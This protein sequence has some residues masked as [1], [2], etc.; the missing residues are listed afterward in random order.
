[1]G[2]TVQSVERAFSILEQF[3]E[4]R[5]SRTAA[6][7]AIEVGLARPTAYRLLQTLQQLGYVRNLN[8]KFEVT[9][10]I[11]RLSAGYLGGHSLAARA[12]PII[13]HLSEQVGEH[14]GI[15]VLDGDDVVTISAADP[16]QSR[17]LAV[18]VRPGQL[19]PAE[20]TS[21][22]RILMAYRPHADGVDAQQIIADGYVVTDG[23]LEDG[24]RSIGVPIRDRAGAVIAS[25]AVASNAVRVSIDDL[26][27]RFLPLLLEA[28]ELITALT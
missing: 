24:L 20:A 3:D 28:A 4:S 27:Q 12:Q 13:D 25:M 26:E 1:M 11:L 8:G 15:A 23:R 18:T 2:A 14:V 16:I 21:L 17:L 10:R 19:L 22:G 5:P 6:E 9:P 7:I